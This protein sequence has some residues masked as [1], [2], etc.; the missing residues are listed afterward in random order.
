MICNNLLKKLRLPVI[1]WDQI[2]SPNQ[3]ALS[4]PHR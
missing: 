3:I 4:I 2:D 1:T